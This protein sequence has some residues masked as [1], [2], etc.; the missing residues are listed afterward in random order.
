VQCLKK[1][2]RIRNLYNVVVPLLLLLLL[3]IHNPL[4]FNGVFFLYFWCEIEEISQRLSSLSDKVN[5]SAYFRR[6]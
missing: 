3:L 5:S 4:N 2:I 1:L 6:K